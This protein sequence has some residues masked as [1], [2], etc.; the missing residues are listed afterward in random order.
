MTAGVH[1]LGAG[2]ASGWDWDG[3][4][5]V[6]GGCLGAR[7]LELGGGTEPS[8]GSGDQEA[9]VAAPSSWGA[10]VAPGAAELTPASAEPEELGT[11]VHMGTGWALE[12]GGDGSIC[13]SEVTAGP[14]SPSEGTITCGWLT[15]GDMALGGDAET[16]PRDQCPT[17]VTAGTEGTGAVPG[18]APAQLDV[19]SD[20]RA[21][22]GPAGG[23][24]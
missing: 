5:V 10:L 19:S 16:V 13:S 2:E 3:D 20:G 21:R 22:D 12:G 11:H 15:P 1:E 4:L 14:L 6:L 8:M 23:C 24:R 18:R 9:P 17:G 7:V